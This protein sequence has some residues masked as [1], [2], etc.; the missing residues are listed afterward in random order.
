[1]SEAL[2]TVCEPYKIKGMTNKQYDKLVSF[3]ATAWN[4]AIL[5]ESQRPQELFKVAQRIPELKDMEQE[6]FI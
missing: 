4:I 3:G 2:L 5:P 1:M 6:E